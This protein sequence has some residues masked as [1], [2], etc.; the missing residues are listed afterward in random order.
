MAY[1]EVVSKSSKSQG[2]SIHKHVVVHFAPAKSAYTG[3]H[4][5]I[6]RL[7]LSKVTSEITCEACKRA[8]ERAN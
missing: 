4:R 8:A 5:F 3:C 6:G 2:L 7:L 1:I